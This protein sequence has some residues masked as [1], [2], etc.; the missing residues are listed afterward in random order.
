MAA[1]AVGFCP[2][3]HATSFGLHD[4]EHGATLLGS[5]DSRGD[6]ATAAAAD[7]RTKGPVVLFFDTD[8]AGVS[9]PLPDDPLALVLRL[10]QAEA[11]P[12]EVVVLARGSADVR[13]VESSLR[14]LYAPGALDVCRWA[15]H[16]DVAQNLGA[17]GIR[18]PL[19]SIGAVEATILSVVRTM[20]AIASAEPFEGALEAEVAG[21]TSR[22]PAAG[23]GSVEC[24]LLRA[25]EAQR[26]HKIRERLSHPISHKECKSLLCHMG[27]EA[28]QRVSLPRA[29]E[30]QMQAITRA[31]ETIQ[32]LMERV[33]QLEYQAAKAEAQRARAVA[34]AQAV[35][36]NCTAWAEANRAR[37]MANPWH[38]MCDALD[39]L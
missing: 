2:R 37:V 4:P 14:S 10:L 33:C 11:Q 39:L 27:L 21:L 36:G 7:V 22:A 24:P 29:S 5:P 6:P 28:P 31:A 20:S 23:A 1:S 38:R 13:D 30:Q 9:G 18:W 35:W 17:H 12:P 8:V 15:D 32:E 19:R 25:Y 34:V 26:V 3:S 16:L